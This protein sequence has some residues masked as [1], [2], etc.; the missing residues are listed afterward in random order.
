MQIIILSVGMAIV[1][2]MLAVPFHD[3]VNPEVV[4]PQFAIGYVFGLI[5]LLA[6][7]NNTNRGGSFK[8]L[9]LPQQIVY[10]IWYALILT[11]DVLRSGAA[12]AWIVVQPKIE[13]DPASFD[14]HTGDH[15]GNS[16]IS[17]I[18]AYS[19]TITP[20]EMVIDFERD[21]DE[22]MHEDVMIVHVLN[23][24]KSNQKTLEVDQNRR[25]HRIKR[26]LAVE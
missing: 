21:A 23:Q 18:S 7:R 8:L 12:V 6:F 20:G 13:I 24:Q 15:S 10:T 4:L 9:R 2:V 1:W 22:D 25:L 17:A 3:V 26:L 16:L 11:L 14:I 5:I 19:I